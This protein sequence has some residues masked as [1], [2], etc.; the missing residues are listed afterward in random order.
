MQDWYARRGYVPYKYVDKMWSE[1]D[2]K[3]RVWWSTA[4]SM[5]KD[6]K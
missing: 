1:K 2:S 4:V 6:I 3:G 5:R